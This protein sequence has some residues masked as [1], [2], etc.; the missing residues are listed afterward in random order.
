[1]ILSRNA[2]SRYPF[3][4]IIN[5]NWNF[6]VNL[7]TPI[8]PPKTVKLKNKN[9]TIVSNTKFYHPANFELK[10]IKTA[11]VI[12]NWNLNF[13][14]NLVTPFSRRNLLK[15]KNKNH[16]IVLNTKFYYPANFELKRMKT[17]NVIPRVSFQAFCW[18]GV[19]GFLSD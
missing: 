1:M 10:R 12:I 19:N 16:T 6:A 4:C 15:P 8:F 9:Q 13:A 3:C 17:S 2:L 11:N 18:P 14:V 5:W 7:V